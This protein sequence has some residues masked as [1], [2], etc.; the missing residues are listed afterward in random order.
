[1]AIEE[2]EL[3]VKNQHLEPE[4]LILL[5]ESARRYKTDNYFRKC[6]AY[7]VAYDGTKFRLVNVNERGEIPVLTPP[8]RVSKYE[9]FS[10]TAPAGSGVSS[11][12][13]FSDVSVYT[14]LTIFLGRV[15]I[16]FML[17]ATGLYG[18]PFRLEEGFYIFDVPA[19]EITIEEYNSPDNVDVEIVVW[20]A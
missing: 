13:Q 5:P 1:M 15:R 12:F 18:D 8:G 17:E 4:G 19:R 20:E 11:V 6:L 7:L 2:K 10:F 9:V 14:Q 3:E 16:K